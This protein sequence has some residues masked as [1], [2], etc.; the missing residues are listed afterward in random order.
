[1]PEPSELGESWS[2]ES[3]LGAEPGGELPTEFR[4]DVEA[5][6]DV[7]RICPVGELD[8]DTVGEVRA[9][10]EELRSTGF[11]RLILDLRR[12]TFLD[13]TGLRLAVDENSASADDGFAFAIF[14]GPPAVQRAFEVSGLASQLPFVEPGAAGLGPS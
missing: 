6:G 13:S 7:A 2:S 1:V 9:Q 8:L 11:S 4:V 5:E 14:A 12:T 10:L 3:R